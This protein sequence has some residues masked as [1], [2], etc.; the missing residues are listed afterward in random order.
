[1]EKHCQMHY[2]MIQWVSDVQVSTLVRSCESS[3][4]LNEFLTAS[5]P[6]PWFC[7]MFLRVYHSAIPR[8]IL[9]CFKKC[10]KHAS[11][12]GDT[13]PFI[14]CGI[15]LG[16]I[17]W[18]WIHLRCLM[19]WATLLQPGEKCTSW[20]FQMP[21]YT[22]CKFYTILEMHLHLFQIVKSTQMLLTSF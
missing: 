6:F 17:C 18:I 12:C 10:S 2:F 5:S 3:Q 7:S 13:V 1:M 16:K 14:W 15:F 4:H 20:H 21:Y 8:R 9:L 19:S 22:Y 11:I